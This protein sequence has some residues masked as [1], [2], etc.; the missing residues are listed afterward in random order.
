MKRPASTL[1]GFRVS[2][3][4]FATLSSQ[5]DKCLEKPPYLEKFLSDLT[6]RWNVPL[7]QKVL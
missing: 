3:T 6:A 5:R 4:I 2:V 1:W 7:H